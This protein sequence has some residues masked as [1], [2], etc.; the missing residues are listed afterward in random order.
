MGGWIRV[1]AAG[2][3]IWI[4][5]GNRGYVESPGVARRMPD[6]EASEV[7]VLTTKNSK[8]RPTIVR[9]CRKSRRVASPPPSLVANS[10]ATKPSSSLVSSSGTVLPQTSSRR[11]RRQSIGIPDSREPLAWRVVFGTIC[12]TPVSSVVV[13]TSRVLT[14]SWKG[15]SM[16]PVRLTRVAAV[17][18]MVVRRFGW[19]E[20]SSQVMKFP[21][22]L[23][24]TGLP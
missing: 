7:V 10:T 20:V 9:R 11:D 19:R 24:L 21:P 6:L 15:S 16:A 17:E 14:L 13:T 22:A 5:D 4:Y 18:A 8:A 3:V 1:L 23:E 2:W 12:P